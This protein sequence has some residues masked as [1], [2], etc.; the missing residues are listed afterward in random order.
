MTFSAI[1]VGDNAKSPL[2][3]AVT[4]GRG[5]TSA[6]NFSPYNLYIPY[7]NIYIDIYIMLY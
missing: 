5:R 1:Y 7:I 4:A 3:K 2:A 6:A